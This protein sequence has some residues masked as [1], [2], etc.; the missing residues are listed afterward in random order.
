[1]PKRT[2]LA[3]RAVA[4]AVAAGVVA[5]IA[6][7]GSHNPLPGT[8]AGG[9]GAAQAQHHVTAPAGGRV[10]TTVHS[11]VDAAMPAPVRDLP[12]GAVNVPTAVLTLTD[13]THATAS[14]TLLPESGDTDLTIDPAQQVLAALHPTAGSD[15][16]Q[17]QALLHD[18]VLAAYDGLVGDVV[19]SEVVLTR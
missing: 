16:T 12:A 4:V 5:G 15:A 11:A 17:L 14:L 2:I 18:T 9:L 3:R 1:M 10:H 6:V 8:I 7:I 19:V 13:G